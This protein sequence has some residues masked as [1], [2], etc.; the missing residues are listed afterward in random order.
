MISGMRPSESEKDGGQ[1]ER[2]VSL[3][4]EELNVDNVEDAVPVRKL[5]DPKRT[6]DKEVSEHYLTHLLFKNCTHIV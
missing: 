2:E 5:V 6:S 3:I 4:K 1:E